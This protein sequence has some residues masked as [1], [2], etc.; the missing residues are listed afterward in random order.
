[1]VAAAPAAPVTLTVTSSPAWPVA[2]ATPTSG[3]AA[4]YSNGSIGGSEVSRS[5]N[6]T[7]SVYRIDTLTRPAGWAAAVQ[8]S[9]V[10]VSDCCTQSADPRRTSGV[11]LPSRRAPLKQ[12]ERPPAADAAAGLT[13][14]TTGATLWARVARVSEVYVAPSSPT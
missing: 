6:P 10:A 5:A 12:I 9:W 4:T 8:Q 7:L 14:S 2:G 1:M 13:P 3:G 11:P